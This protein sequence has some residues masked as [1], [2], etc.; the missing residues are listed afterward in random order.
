MVEGTDGRSLA[1]IEGESSRQNQVLQPLR[2]ELHTEHCTLHTTQCTLHTAHYTLY[3]ANCTLL[4]AHCTL[5]TAHFARHTFITS[6]RYLCTPRVQ[7]ALDMVASFGRALA[8]STQLVSMLVVQAWKI[9]SEIGLHFNSRSESTKD[10]AK[11]KSN[12]PTKVKTKFEAIKFH[13]EIVEFV[14]GN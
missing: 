2:P 4:T 11:L 9:C 7:S 10:V 12:K 14:Y 8:W 6:T 13:L 1:K 3:T 5:Y